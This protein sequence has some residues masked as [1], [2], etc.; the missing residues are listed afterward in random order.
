[1][2]RGIEMLVTNPL[3]HSGKCMYVPHS[4]GSRDSV[5]GIANRLQAGLSGVRVRAASA[6]DLSLLQNFRSGSGPIQ[7]PVSG[8]KSSFPGI[9]RT[10]REIYH[11][12]LPKE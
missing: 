4:V 9:K 10:G 7:S 12:F 5:I 1:M 11:L 3:K 6:T 2:K 8:Y